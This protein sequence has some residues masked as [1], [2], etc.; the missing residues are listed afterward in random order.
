MSFLASLSEPLWFTPASAIMKTLLIL[1][2]AS[3]ILSTFAFAQP[4]QA[5]NQVMEQERTQNEIQNR[6]RTMNTN[7]LLER[8]GTMT[9]QR[10][11]EQ[12]HQ[13]LQNRY[14][15]MTQE[16]KRRFDQHP[17]ENRI[18]KGMGQGSGMGGGKGR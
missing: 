11:R 4:V 18:K 15:T 10:D 1:V 16:Q 2:S 8:R 12:L 5:T 13:E 17:P 7:E 3:A 9:Q 14:Q 6:F